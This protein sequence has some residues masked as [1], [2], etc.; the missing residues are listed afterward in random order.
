MV[1]SR[2]IIN[3]SAVGG[4]FTEV[5][6]QQPGI[7]KQIYISPS[8]QTTTFSFQLLDEDDRIIYE[9]DDCTGRQNELIELPVYSNLSLKITDSSVTD[10]TYECLVTSQTS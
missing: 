2:R 7:V 10:E 1:I 8:T 5:V 3:A 4:T 9:M 6:L